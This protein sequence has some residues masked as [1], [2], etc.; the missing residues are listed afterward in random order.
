MPTPQPGLDPWAVQK[1]IGTRDARYALGALLGPAP[2]GPL[3]WTLGVLPSM[4]VGGQLVDL[5]VYPD[6]PT[7]SLSLRV[8]AGQA[9]LVRP[10][11]GPYVCTLDQLGRVTLDPADSSHARIDLIVAVITDER[12]GDPT[13]GF[14]VLP[15]TGRP[16]ATPQLPQVPDGALVLAEVTVGANVTQLTSGAIQ[17]RRKGAAMRTGIHVPFPGDQAAAGG[18]FGGQV[19]FRNGGLEYWDATANLWKGTHRLETFEQTVIAETS[20]QTGVTPI[21]TMVIPDPGYPYRLVVHGSA[22]LTSRDCRADLQTR[23]FTPTGQIVGVGVGAF[24][25]GAW[26]STQVRA[27]GVI[28]GSHSLY[29]CGSR[30]YPESGT[31]GSAPHNGS[32]FA[33]RIPA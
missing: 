27:T 21:A 12:I 10:G 3:A 20:G 23:L 33:L 19:R 5:K 29:L 22:E 28:T 6:T 8:Q 26:V 24:N 1:K 17:D 7:P 13:T 32:L 16:S 25:A 30:I 15:I 4:S 2:G 9:V 14:A 18:A 31:W 11:Q